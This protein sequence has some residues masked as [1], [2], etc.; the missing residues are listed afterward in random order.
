MSPEKREN[1]SKLAAAVNSAGAGHCT[2]MQI[3]FIA[4]FATDVVIDPTKES[5]DKLRGTMQGLCNELNGKIQ[6][7]EFK[8]AWETTSP[9]DPLFSPFRQRN[10]TPYP[11]VLLESTV[12]H[13]GQFDALKES[14]QCEREFPRINEQ[15]G[16]Y[17]V[18]IRKIRIRIY[19]YGFGNLTV[20]TVLTSPESFAWRKPDSASCDKLEAEYNQ[21]LKFIEGCSSLDD[22]QPNAAEYYPVI[23]QY[24]CLINC[25]R[26]ALDE[27]V[28]SVP[29][30]YPIVNRKDRDDLLGSDYRDTSILKKR[31]FLWVHRLFYLPVPCSTTDG[32]A[33][34][35]LCDYTKTARKV[36]CRLT[37]G[38]EVEGLTFKHC[39]IAYI[40]PGSSF[41]L[42][43]GMCPLV[44]QCGEHPSASDQRESLCIDDNDVTHHFS[45]V[46]QTVGVLDAATIELTN[47]LDVVMDTYESFRRGGASRIT[48]SM[49][50]GFL[51]RIAHIRSL[52]T[53]HY[54]SLSPVG[55]KFLAAILKEWRIEDKWRYINWRFEALRDMHDRKGQKTL[56]DTA[57]V[58]STVATIGVLLALLELT[59]NESSS[60]DPSA[61]LLVGLLVLAISL[62]IAVAAILTKPRVSVRLNRMC[63][64]FQGNQIASRMLNL[65]KK[66]RIIVQSLKAFLVFTAV[67]LF[68]MHLLS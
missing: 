34:S 36:F 3:N 2:E 49:I 10:E 50:V 58:F 20:S 38:T 57:L 62:P 33:E 28:S 68:L 31:N 48:D 18:E 54:S 1:Q 41:A 56:N 47:S 22:C 14:F 15:E 27:I 12:K 24:K 67:F 19:H 65:C 29:D 11:A 35:N 52:V 46:L 6:G 43:D 44:L 64:F 66:H 26:E 42:V 59:R 39:K 9:D 40:S 7:V 30:S 25:L 23:K 55:F 63:A 16:G 51:Q 60:F 4:P 8:L 61:S 32:S 53:Q 21:L 45:R 17:S 13:A 5:G 37:E